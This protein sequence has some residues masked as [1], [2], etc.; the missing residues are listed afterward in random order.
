MSFE[1]IVRSRI[2]A[3]VASL[4][5]GLNTRHSSGVT[6]PFTTFSPRPNAPLITT[7]LRKPV[8][9]SS[10]NATPEDPRS[11]RTMRCTATESATLRWG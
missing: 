9:V 1:P 8:S 3:T 2:G 10:V 11:E 5:S 6:V 4:S 7:R